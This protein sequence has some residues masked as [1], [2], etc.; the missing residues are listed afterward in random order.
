M[1]PGDK[2]KVVTK[3]ETI[4]GVLVPSPELEKDVVIIKL[5]SGYNIGIE[6]K[7]IKEI[8]LVAVSK[9]K[10]EAAAAVRKD[11]KLPTIS[12]LHTGG[13]IASKVDYKTGGVLAKFSP[14]EM[15][16]LFPELS[17]IANIES[18]QIAKM[19][20]EMARFAHYNVMAKEIEKEVKKGSD[21]IIITHGTDTMHY[22]SAALAFIFD[23]LPIPVILVGAQRSSDRGSSDAANNLIN[24][25]YFIANSEFA[26][27]A[28]CMHET[29]EDKDCLILP[30]TKTRKMH[31]SRRDAFRPINATAV[32]R[33]NFEEKKISF[34]HKNYGR[35]SNK[36]LQL[37][38][39]NEK[40][41]VGIVRTHTNMFASEFECYKNFDGLVIEGTG[42]GHIPNEE[43]DKFTAENKKIQNAVAE[44][45]K[46]GVVVV[47]APQTI[48]GRLQL[49][50]YTPQRELQSIGVLGHLSDMT[51][52]TTFI[53][54]AWLL[55]NYKR[56]E[57]KELITK[58]LRG[59]LS[60]RT[61]EQ[62]FLV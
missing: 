57:A 11:K 37:R 52:E 51:P 15:L 30:A 26:E 2:V 34:L 49:N 27:V 46:E 1:K 62:E 42:L 12:I 41:K 56:E 61:E 48:Y 32:A 50:V 17:A 20:S 54:L 45:V 7:K 55:S 23:N 38:L 28:I 8:K 58:N 40:I 10:K 44:L 29:M 9:E 24:A 3:D 4:E 14:S 36:K 39:F 22:T 53:K 43:I 31:T 6:K 59:E 19:Q 35:K 25:A 16:K 33:V 21:G 18:R 5:D 13:T 60:E 47:M